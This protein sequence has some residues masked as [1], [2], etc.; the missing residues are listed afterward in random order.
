MQGK[1]HD[2][3]EMV[4]QFIRN[5]A[6]ENYMPAG[7]IQKMHTKAVSPVEYQLPIGEALVGLNAL[8]G[9]EL[10]IEFCGEIF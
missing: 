8:L 3:T 6:K 2:P 5:E 7:V 4:D 1:S 10:E 9:R